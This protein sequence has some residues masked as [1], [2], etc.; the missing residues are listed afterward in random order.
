[1]SGPGVFLPP[2][3]AFRSRVLRGAFLRWHDAPARLAGKARIV[4]RI[5][6]VGIVGAGVAG[7]AAAHALRDVAQVHLFEADTSLGGHART[8]DIRLDGRNLAVDTG[9]LV[10]NERTYPGLIRLL[11][12]LGV[13]SAPSDMSFSVQVPDLDLE[14]S[15]ST[16]DTVFAQRANL[17]R[18]AFWGMLRDILRFNRIA[19]ELA[20]ALV[21]GGDQPALSQSMGTFLAAHRFSRPFCDWYFL[22]MVGSIWSCPTD[23]MLE[24]PVETMVRFCDNHGLVQLADRPAWRT[25]R[26]GSRRYVEAIARRLRHSGAHLHLGHAVREVRRTDEGAWIRTD[27]GSLKVDELVLASHSDQSL[28]L[29]ADPSPTERRLLGAIRYQSNLAVL[30]TDTRLLP[31]RRRA[32]AAW[33]YERAANETLERSQV[34]LHYW[35]NRLQPL[36]VNTPVIETLNPVRP[37]RPESVLETHAFAHPVFDRGAIQAQQAFP[38][39]QGQRR[40]WYAGAWLGYGF[41][42]DGLSSGLAAARG[43]L[44]SQRRE[45]APPPRLAELQA[46]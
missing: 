26:G 16:L 30:H 35:L 39:L 41:H 44:A 36:P 38:A 19:R 5:P 40:T 15:G 21:S 18:P 8:R 24:F 45:P 12:E 1:M 37:P 4:S 32:W 46:A 11:D 25:V 34:C 6:V 14:W 13:D 9:F 42:E 17:A 10:Y 29:L 28:A 20:R 7:L 23:Q 22:P 33:N 27:A 3:I 2:P 43:I 31:Q